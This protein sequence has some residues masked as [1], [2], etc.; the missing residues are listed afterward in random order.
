MTTS[1]DFFTSLA[2]AEI[3][4]LDFIRE[5][6][7]CGFLDFLC[8][9]L[10]YLC[11]HGEIW[12]ALALLFLCLPKSRRMGLAMAFSLLI[13]VFAVNCF[14][15]PFIFRVRPY[16]FAQ[17]SIIVK[18]LH[19]GSFPSGHTAASFEACTAMLYYDRRVGVPA[20]ILAI[21][22]AFSRLYLYVHYPSDVLASLLLGVLIGV[23]GIVLSGLAFR[24]GQ[25]K[26][27][28]FFMETK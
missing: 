16:D 6:F 9:F 1:L 24:K 2:S 26:Q 20:L 28:K 19:D 8:P 3:P 17:V 12:I 21:G 4:V 22:I 15:K 14:L 10:S 7:A 18:P 27:F 25:T 23:C 13:G 11:A 5:H